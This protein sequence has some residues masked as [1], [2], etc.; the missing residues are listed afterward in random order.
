VDD[1]EGARKVGEEDGRGLE[2][3]DE[4][5]LPAVVGRADLGPELLDARPEVLGGEVDLADPG[6]SD[7]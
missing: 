7:Y 3:G 6:I 5:R 1:R 4:N 2:R